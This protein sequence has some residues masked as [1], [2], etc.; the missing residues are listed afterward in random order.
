MTYRRRARTIERVG[1][2]AVAVAA[3]V[4]FR[5]V[6]TGGVF[7]MVLGASSWI[8]TVLV[9]VVALTVARGAVA[10][11]AARWLVPARRELATAESRLRAHDATYGR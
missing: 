2:L 5:I 4:G 6:W 1:G 7:A 8:L 3:A 9:F 11:I 10:T